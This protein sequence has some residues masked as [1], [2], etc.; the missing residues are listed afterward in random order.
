MAA[1]S[2]EAN[3]R[4]KTEPTLEERDP[5]T[6]SFPAKVALCAGIQDAKPDVAV[7]AEQVKNEQESEPLSRAAINEHNSGIVQIWKDFFVASKNEP[8]SI[9]EMT[10]GTH[11][12]DSFTGETRANVCKLCLS[13]LVANWEMFTFIRLDDGSD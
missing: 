10:D 8:M 1:S 9:D 5:H 2:S 12:A 4:V 6:L 3:K 11:S 13:P 7:K